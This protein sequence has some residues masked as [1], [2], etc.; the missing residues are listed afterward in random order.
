MPV[1]SNTQLVP[2]QNWILRV[3]PAT[4][5]P[6][7][8]LVLIHGL[9]GDENSMW[10]F[11]RNFAEDYWIIAPRAPYNAN[12]PEGGYSWWPRKAGSRGS[13]DES[14]GTPSLENMHPSAEALINLIDIYA[15]ENKILATTFDV[16]G[17]SQGGVL[18]YALGLLY[19]ERIRRSAI[20]ASFIPA[21]SETLMPKSLLKNKPFFIAHGTLDEKVEIES[22]RRSVEMLEKAGA[23][24][25]FCEDEVGHKLS[26]HCLRAL[27]G[28]FAN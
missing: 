17:F 25:M 26:S 22:A 5:K 11:A 16:M 19:P 23:E 14:V 4:E 24:V 2:F 27:E 13:D 21:N 20:L 9:T 6:R 7:R 28:F 10:V 8:L 18:A 12:R 1:L 15:S 3:R